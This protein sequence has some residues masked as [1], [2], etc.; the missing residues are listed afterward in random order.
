MNIFKEIKLL[1]KENN[2]LRKENAKLEKENKTWREIAR[3]SK[4]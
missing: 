3:I 2:E 1:R 4:K